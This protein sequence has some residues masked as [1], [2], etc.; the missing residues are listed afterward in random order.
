MN[1]EIALP[2]V[3]VV[4][5]PMEDEALV[6]V[7]DAMEK[8][9]MGIRTKNNWRMTILEPDDESCVKRTL[10]RAQSFKGENKQA[11]W[12]VCTGQIKPPPLT[13]IKY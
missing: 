1:H 7:E 9:Q 4:S 3:V 12:S 6:V 2:V 13:G 11:L 10:P 5:F 8:E